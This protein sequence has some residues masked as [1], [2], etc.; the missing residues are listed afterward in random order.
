[1]RTAFDRAAA[2]RR[3]HRRVRGRV[4]GT[5]VR[6]R[7][8]VYRSLRHVYA[9]LIDDASGRTLVA[10]ATVEPGVQAVGATCG[11]AAV[12]GRTLAERATAAGITRAV[13]DRGGYL[14]H[15]RVRAVAD[16][17]RAAGLEF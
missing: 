3:R 4:S 16:A 5:A 12:V 9:Q 11:S 15:G 6:P 10:A 1:M 13:F 17:A 2:R 14:Y 8:C 7:L